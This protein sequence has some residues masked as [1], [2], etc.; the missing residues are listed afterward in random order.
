MRRYARTF[1]SKYDFS[2]DGVRTRELS[3]AIL[4]VRLAIVRA[5]AVELLN[6]EVI[7]CVLATD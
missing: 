7:C 3:S 4:D 6:K 5:Q 1:K 2:V